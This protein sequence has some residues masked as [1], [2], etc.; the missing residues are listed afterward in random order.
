MASGRIQRWALTLGAYKYV[1]E[2]KNGVQNADALSRLPLPSP[3]SNSDVPQVAEVV[4]LMDYLDT[5]LVTSKKIRLGTDSETIF[6]CG[7]CPCSGFVN[8]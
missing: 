8:P 1:I 2:F 5:S 6:S 4:N 3:R 7:Y